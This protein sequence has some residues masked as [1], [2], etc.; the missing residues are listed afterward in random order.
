[1]AMEFKRK[2]AFVQLYSRFLSPQHILNG[3]V[4]GQKLVYK[5]MGNLKEKRQAYCHSINII[6]YSYSMQKLL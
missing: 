6:Q 4:T 5:W 2:T 1:M 3:N